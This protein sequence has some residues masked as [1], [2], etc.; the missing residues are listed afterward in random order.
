M[1]FQKGYMRKI[2]S[3]YA[4]D[5]HLATMMLPYL[6]KKVK[7][8]VQINTILDKDMEKYMKELLERINIEEEIK[9][10]I[11]AI[12]WKNSQI[13]QTEVEKFLKGKL[14]P[15]TETI[16]ITTIQDDNPIKEKINQFIKMNLDFIIKNNIKVNLIQCYEVS[17]LKDINKIINEYDFVLNTSGIHEIKEVFGCTIE[18]EEKRIENKFVG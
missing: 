12:N 11:Q 9:E 1:K 18:K 14:K 15:N 2:C 13:N 5:C 16:I 3:F 7:T 8:D 10:K 6:V 17:R 4:G